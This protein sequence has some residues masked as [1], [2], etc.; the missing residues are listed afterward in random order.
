MTA[1][2]YP[3]QQDT[4]LTAI[5]SLLVT[6]E[7]IN[8]STNLSQVQ[9]FVN[10][11]ERKLIH[12]NNDNLYSTF[13]S[14]GD[15]VRI[16]ITTTSAN[17]E[18]D[19]TRRD[20][21]TDDQGGDMGIRDVYITG[22]TGNSPTTLEVTFTVSPISLDYNFEYLISA[23]VQYPVTPTP[24]PTNTVTP[25]VTPTNTLT[26]TPTTP[27]PFQN[28]FVAGGGNTIK[29]SS[30][31]LNWS[32]S[33]N[34]GSFSMDFSLAAYC[35]GN[36]YMI[37][38]GTYGPAAPFKVIYSYD[39]NYW[40]STNFNYYMSTLLNMTSNGNIWLI[41]GSTGG[42]SS[43][44]YYSY[45]KIDWYP[46]SLNSLWP[47]N[48][49]IHSVFW[50]G[51]QF[52]VTLEYTS[53]FYS[54]YDGINWTTNLT[55]PT[56]DIGFFIFNGTNYIGYRATDG[57]LYYSQD[58]YTFTASTPLDLPS[59]QSRVL[60]AGT[61]IFIGTSINMYRS[62]NNGVSWTTV[63]SYNALQPYAQ[64][65]AYNNSI[66]LANGG[67][68]AYS[69]DGI[70][71][72]LG[73]SSSNFNAQFIISYP[74]SF[75]TVQAPT[76][77]PTPTPTRTQ[78]PTPTV[79]PTNTPTISVTPT[80]T[81]TISV[82]PSITPTNTPTISLTPTNTNTPTITPTPSSTPGFI[83]IITSGLTI[84]GDANLGHSYPG[85]GTIITDLSGNGY[86]GNLINGTSFSGGTPNSFKY[87]GVNDYIQFPGY[88]GPGNIDYTWGC[89]VRLNSGLPTM[90]MKGQ[91]SSDWGLRLEMD[92]TGQFNA[93]AAAS[94]TSGG[95]VSGIYAYSTTIIPN[96][97][98]WYYIVGVWDSATSIKFYLNGVLE[99]TTLTTRGFLRNSTLG[100]NSGIYGT[101]FSNNWVADFEVY[102]RVL[103]DAEVL[104]NYN[105]N[106]SKY[107]Y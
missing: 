94:L 62:T 83:P 78:T 7:E 2:V 42:G 102:A 43:A 5:G 20:Y 9:C 1:R 53:K 92:A 74:N 10:T 73:N 84:Y 88:N 14:N 34:G 64:S 46:S 91:S 33:V 61:N 98:S 76:P 23:S 17:N 56:L 11:I 3:S 106:K 21:T 18:I 59:E 39:G 68:M 26:P 75:V 30:D 22:V 57:R 103:S 50:N 90:W 49:Q 89:W 35:D 82:T 4:Y 69:Y 87:D 28:V 104:Y 41:G 72:S 12:N 63:P 40:F 25:T 15:I 58:L 95:T 70:N 101:T 24:T 8:Q 77:T 31:G 51:N 96:I 93:G 67:R 32:N 36:A 47:S 97:T 45:N 86:N 52:I 13:I 81:P 107:G 29:Y 80:N 71:W 55:S 99:S 105:A 6:Y 100:W 27:P 44:L 85:T 60:L 54:S 48:I 79:T 19:V 66:Y 38:G 37:I 16:L 65:L